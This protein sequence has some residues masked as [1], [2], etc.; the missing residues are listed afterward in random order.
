MTYSTDDHRALLRGRAWGLDPERS[1]AEFRVPTYWGLTTVHGRFKRLSGSLR[2]D[3]SIQLTI[4][5][6]SLRT[7][8]FLR[9]RHLRS[10]DFFDTDRHP[11][12]SFRSPGLERRPDGSW[13]LSGELSAAGHRLAL[14]LTPTV[15][16]TDDHLQI[17]AETSVD[18]HHLGMTVTRFGIRTPATLT[19]H[20]DLRLVT[21][22]AP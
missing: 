20:A 2:T 4:D 13:R 15:D 14:D 5:A 18:Q 8:N 19:V 7:G 16:A 21:S 22:A 12:V 11:E 1:S 17:A 6:A 3:G 10:A 9:D